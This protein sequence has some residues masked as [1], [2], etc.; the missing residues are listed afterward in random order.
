[1]ILAGGAGERF[2][3]ASRARRPKPLL[4]LG[5]AGTLLAAALSRARRFAARDAV[6][7]V[8]GREQADAI[9]RAA[10][11]PA[12][13]ILVEPQRRNT[14]LAV[15]LAATW[16]ERADPGALLAVLPAD[17][18]IPD[19]AAFARAIA[20]AAR[21]AAGA[22]V[23][24]TLGVRPTR[25]DPGYGYIR[26]G[27]PAGPGWPGLRRVRRFVE[28][29]DAARARRFLR[30]GDHL[31][32]A[33]IFVFSARVLL[34]E[35]EACAPEIHAAL[36]P[37]RGARGTPSARLLARCYRGAPSL[38]IDVA[39]I[40]KTRAV[41]TLPVR[42]RWSDVGTWASLAEELGVASGATRVVGGELLYDERGGN[43]VFGPRRVALLG[44]AGVAVVDTGDVLLVTKLERSPD[45]RRIVA[46][47]KTRGRSDVL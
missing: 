2:W 30:G 15:A 45:V 26:V 24:V 8:C 3:P 44:L 17:H 19:E 6:W 42:F 12:R 34:R 39:V 37:L 4:R 32:N 28:K 16:I 29:P 43:L 33:G 9:R 14:A 47:L 20:R 23:I 31:W 13:R 1:V 10:R 36:A 40:E 25:A 41:W 22:G 46:A 38:P 5:G 21:A 7:V 18:R 11:L 27:P 35:L